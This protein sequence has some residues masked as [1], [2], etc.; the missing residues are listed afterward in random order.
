VLKFFSAL[1]RV[2]FN[3]QVLSSV[4]SDVFADLVLRGQLEVKRFSDCN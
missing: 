1:F 2:N 3:N 4:S